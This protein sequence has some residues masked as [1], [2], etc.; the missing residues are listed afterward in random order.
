M[1]PLM[2]HDSDVEKNDHTCAEVPLERDKSG[3]GAERNL[4]QVFWASLAYRPEVRS[5]VTAEV[6]L[7]MSPTAFHPP[8]L[9]AL[10]YGFLVGWVHLKLLMVEGTLIFSVMMV[11]CS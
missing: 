9:Q 1:F 6:L 3:R 5:R 2:P 10:L 11:P 7:S 8:L 4:A